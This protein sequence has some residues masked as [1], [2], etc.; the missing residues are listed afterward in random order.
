MRTKLISILGSAI[1]ITSALVAPY[2]IKKPIKALPVV[3]K[4]E[5]DVQAFRQSFFD[6][7]RVYG[8]AGCGDVALAEQTARAAAKTGLPA[9][10]IAAEIAV[11]SS[12]NPLA[13]SHDGGIGLTQVMPSIW[14]SRYNSFRD[15][16]LLKA[17][18]SIDVGTAILAENVS[19]YGLRAGIRH[20]NGSGPAAEI[21]ATKVTALA[22]TR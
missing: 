21:Y 4:S 5:Y 15:K 22:G 19:L 13:V 7:A 6:A 16:N 12:C 9:A 20:Y 2:L 17:E 11:E 3:Q 8:R 18:D 10:V 14:A 1:T